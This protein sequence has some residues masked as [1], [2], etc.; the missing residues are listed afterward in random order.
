MLL[1]AIFALRGTPWRAQTRLPHIFEIFA[2]ALRG[3][4]V[5]CTSRASTNVRNT[6]IPTMMLQNPKLRESQTTTKNLQ[7][8]RKHKQ[9]KRSDSKLF[10]LISNFIW[11]RAFVCNLCPAWHAVGGTSKASTH[12]SNLRPGPAWPRRGV[13]KQGLYECSKNRNAANT[14]A[15]EP[16]RVFQY[17]VHGLHENCFRYMSITDFVFQSIYSLLQDPG[18]TFGLTLPGKSQ[19]ASQPTLDLEQDRL[20]CD[21]SIHAHTHPHSHAHIHTNIYYTCCIYVYTTYTT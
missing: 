14:D 2:L 17:S 20:P 21:A 16:K 6:E 9:T 3:H 11:L 19:P 10:A 15:R 13:H 18:N 1:F 4:A 12:L 5:V 7:K 8:P